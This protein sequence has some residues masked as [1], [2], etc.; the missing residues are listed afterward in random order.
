MLLSFYVQL[1]VNRVDAQWAAVKCLKV[2]NATRPCT[3]RDA[4]STRIDACMNTLEFSPVVT[5]DGV[6]RRVGPPGAKVV[7]VH[8][9]GPANGCIFENCAKAKES[10]PKENKLD[11]WAN[12]KYTNNSNTSSNSNNDILVIRDPANNSR[13]LR[14]VFTVCAIIAALILIAAVGSMCALVAKNMRAL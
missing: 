4:T 6:R 14:I 10:V 11:C 12:T 7:L 3:Y 1:T 5:L 8:N 2:G 13:K 9:E